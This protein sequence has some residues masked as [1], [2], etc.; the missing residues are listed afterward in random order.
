[1]PRTQ[2]ETKTNKTVRV[3]ETKFPFLT[4]TAAAETTTLWMVEWMDGWADG[5]DCCN[6][7][8]ERNG[9]FYD[10]HT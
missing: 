5:L 4:V 7:D 1:M 8:Y 9:I 3:I 10:A 2:K 6:V